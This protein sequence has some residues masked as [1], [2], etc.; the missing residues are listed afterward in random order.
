MDKQLLNNLSI[1][2]EIG[3]IYYNYDEENDV[4]DTYRIMRIQNEDTV[5]CMINNDPKQ[6]QKVK[7]AAL[8]KHFQLL[9]SNIVLSVSKVVAA[10]NEHGMELEDI[11]IMGHVRKEGETITNDE[12]D[13]VCRQSLSDI[14]YQVF[15]NEH[16]N[17]FVG[18]SVTK[19]TCPV[20]YTMRALTAMDH[21]E[22]SI[23]V[24]IYRTD[25]IDD[26]LKLVDEKR[27]NPTLLKLY[28]DKIK[29]SERTY[30]LFTPDPSGVE[31]GF[32]QN[33]RSLFINNNFMYDLYGLLGIMQVTFKIDYPENDENGY[34]LPLDQKE[35]LQQLYETNME[36][37]IV[38]PFD[39]SVDLSKINMPYVLIMDNTNTLYLVGFTKSVN[40]YAKTYSSIPEDMKAVR[41][42]LSN[43][44]S[45]YDKY[46]NK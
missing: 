34:S 39:F 14:F 23:I 24:N 11:I 31:Y 17:P 19:H 38:A 43:A 44:V 28:E 36:K 10:Q 6:I 26:I 21:L 25:T 1:G 22:D 45:Y 4:V 18:I 32:C 2:S 37:T 35:L 9:L 7:L 3:N 33:L 16:E 27:W 13:I 29:A 15:C 42:K 5:S 8:K 20:E 41:E 12:P 30:P 46:S 40:E